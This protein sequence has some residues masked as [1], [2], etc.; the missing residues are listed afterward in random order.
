[1]TSKIVRF[2]TLLVE[3]TI[4]ICK[5]L[6]VTPQRKRLQRWGE[7]WAGV[8]GETVGSHLVQQFRKIQALLDKL[9]VKRKKREHTNCGRNTR[10]DQQTKLVASPF[11]PTCAT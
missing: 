5:I 3:E 9:S 6:V 7:R 4:Y 2:Y 11:Y 10:V 8:A 1:M